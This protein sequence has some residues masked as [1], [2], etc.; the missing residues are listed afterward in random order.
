[1][2]KIIIAA[3]VASTA[4]TGAAFAQETTSDN[5]PI[6]PQPPYLDQQVDETVFETEGANATDETFE[7]TVIIRNM[8]D[9]EEGSDVRR[10]Y[11]VNE[12]GSKTLIAET[13]M[14]SDSQ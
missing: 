5:D 2:K 10:I 6:E 3:F 12:D 13:V 8:Y 1:M 9:E 7:G 4:L 11:R 14:G